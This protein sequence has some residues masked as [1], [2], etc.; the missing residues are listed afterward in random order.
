[1]VYSTVLLEAFHEACSKGLADIVESLLMYDGDILTNEKG[2]TS[3]H[4][5]TKKNKSGVIQVLLKWYLSMLL[6]RACL[7]T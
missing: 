2:Q 6:V 4:I 5:A 3:L 1:M 7:H